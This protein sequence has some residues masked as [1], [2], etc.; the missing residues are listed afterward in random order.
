MTPQ[1]RR[2]EASL[3][4]YA[5][6]LALTA[7]GIKALADAIRLW[8]TVSAE[9]SR[10]A[11]TAASWI[12]QAVRFILLRRR[13]TRALALAYYR[14]VR[15]LHTGHTLPSPDGTGGRVPLSVLRRRFL[16]A[17][18]L[19]APE[20][21]NDPEIA[22][23]SLQQGSADL[24][25]VIDELEDLIDALE[26]DSTAEEEAEIILDALGPRNLERKLEQIRDDLPAREVDRL[27]EEARR[28]VARRQAA[29]AERMIKNGGRG[30]VFDLADKDDQVLGWARVSMT[31]TPCGWCAM[32]ISRGPVYKSATSA[33][34]GLDHEGDLYHDNCNCIAVP[35]FSEEQYAEDPRFNLNREYGQLWPRVT[36]GLGGKAALSKWRKY[37]RKNETN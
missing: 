33:S 1:E 36:A 25:V 17:L 18:G 19:Y 26:D 10:V 16:E 15:A 5:F 29:A 4:T 37:F 23:S 8:A 31:G 27:R 20:V 34:I 13:D 9:P 22:S 11:P 12:G 6:H 21:L 24:E 28:A 30:A 35:V 32:L 7:M 3:V 14:L 2:A